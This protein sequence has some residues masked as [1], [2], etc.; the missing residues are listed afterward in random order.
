MGFLENIMKM[1]GGGGASADSNPAAAI[2]GALQ[3]GMGSMDQNSLAGIGQQLLKSFTDT[4]AFNGTGAD[5]AA[6]AGVDP[7]HV[8]QGNAGAIGGLLEIAKQHP[9]VVQNAVQG[10]MQN[11]PQLAQQLMPMLG[12]LLGKA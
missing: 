3:Q 11:N 10:V 9:E 2:A 12:S 5:A 7:T 8:E 6:A 1:V 4:Q